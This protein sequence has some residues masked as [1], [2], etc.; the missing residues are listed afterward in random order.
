MIMSEDEVV[1]IIPGCKI[2]RKL[3]QRLIFPAELIF[4]IM[5]E[6]VVLRPPVAE[7]EGQPRMQGTE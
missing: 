1:D 2:E 7:S 6:A 5:S 4:H 3:I